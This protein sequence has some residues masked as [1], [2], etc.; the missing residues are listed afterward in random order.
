[1]RVAD[2]GCGP[3]R[4]AL[5][6]LG[7]GARLTLADLSRI[8]LNLARGRI[9]GAGFTASVDGYHQLDVSDLSVL[10][11]GAFDADVCYGGVLSYARAQHVQAIEEL[12]RI[13]KPEAPIVISVMSLWGTMALLGTLDAAGFIEAPEAHLD[14]D[15][16]LVAP[17]SCSRSRALPSFT[18]RSR[19]SRPRARGGCSRKPAARW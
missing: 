8:Q 3:G 9:E 19:Y 17:M 11:D 1:M 10:A 7:A 12:V 5:D 14:W 15:E 16:L 6:A 13:A 2:I 4:F 18:S